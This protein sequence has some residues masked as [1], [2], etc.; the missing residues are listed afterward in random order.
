MRLHLNEPQRRK[1]PSFSR[2]F[3]R[4]E[5]AK[6]PHLSSLTICS[7]VNVIENFGSCL[8]SSNPQIIG[9][10]MNSMTCKMLRQGPRDQG[11]HR[12][13]I[14]MIPSRWSFQWKTHSF[15][16]NG[17]GLRILAAVITAFGARVYA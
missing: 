16:T 12:Q 6:P 14:T 17:Y 5:R 8:G 4:Y 1:W 10:S 7:L 9:V 15:E 11:S 13:W 2:P 3:P